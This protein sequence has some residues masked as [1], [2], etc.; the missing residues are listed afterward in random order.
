MPLVNDIYETLIK[1]PD[2]DI[3]V[4]QTRHEA[5]KTEA[6]ERARQHYNNVQALSLAS[7][8]NIS[9]KSLPK[10]SDNPFANLGKSLP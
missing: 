4:G 8:P 2:L 1:D 3:M 5:A 9:A 10:F 7:A 6:E